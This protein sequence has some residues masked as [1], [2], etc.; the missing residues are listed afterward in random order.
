MFG[1]ILSYGHVISSEAA[2]QQLAQAA[3]EK[4]EL[5]E[6]ATTYQVNKYNNYELKIKFLHFLVEAYLLYIFLPT[7]QIFIS[8]TVFLCLCC[9]GKF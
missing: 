1:L 3:A 5:E 8:F 6:I 7:E 4:S 2:E 9:V